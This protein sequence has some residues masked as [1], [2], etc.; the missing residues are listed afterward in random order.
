MWQSK[1]NPPHYRSAERRK[2]PST[3]RAQTLIS[4]WCHTHEAPGQDIDSPC[5][6]CYSVFTKHLVRIVIGHYGYHE[7][8]GR[9]L[10]AMQLIKMRGHYHHC[11]GHFVPS[12]YGCYSLL[13]C[14]HVREKKKRFLWHV[15]L[16]ACRTRFM[17]S[18][19][20]SLFGSHAGITF[21][22]FIS[23]FFSSPP[24]FKTMNRMWLMYCVTT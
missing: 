3:R 14:A 12:N 7:E 21:V 8:T 17:E 18:T 2:H 20:T 15:S 23:S 9:W 4:L 24:Q 6:W 11:Q 5:Q 22:L 16:H 1:W 13:H 10:I 19:H